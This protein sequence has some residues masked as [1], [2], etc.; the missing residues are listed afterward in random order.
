M[1]CACLPE[2]TQEWNQDPESRHRLDPRSAQAF[3]KGTIATTQDE[4]E[5]IRGS[6]NVFRDFDD[7]HADLKQAKAILAAQ[8]IGVLDD[9]K[10][11]AI[12][13]ASL[14]SFAAADFSRLRNADLGRFTLDR[15]FKMLGALD[16]N[17]EVTIQLIP[18]TD[19][20]SGVSLRIDTA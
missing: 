8:I 20:V 13:A 16:E 19:R 15:L 17:I 10:L 4:I 5:L 18:R 14:T 6:G 1:G 11:T 3:E 9:R 7:P 2:K 12:K